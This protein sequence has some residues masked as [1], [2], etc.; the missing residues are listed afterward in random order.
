MERLGLFSVYRLFPAIFAVA[1]PHSAYRTSPPQQIVENPI[2]NHCGN[3]GALGAFSSGTGL[4]IMV[5]AENKNS[6][7]FAICCDFLFRLLL[8]DLDQGRLKKTQR[9]KAQQGAGIQAQ[10][11]VPRLRI[12]AWCL[13]CQA[14]QNLS[15]IASEP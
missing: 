13:P 9:S 6:R 2:Y 3:H 12:G 1:G 8:C 10:P 11:V 15:S 14:L 7:S 4:I 5:H